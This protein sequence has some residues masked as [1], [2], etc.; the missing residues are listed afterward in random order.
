MRHWQ[1]VSDLI[2]NGAYTAGYSDGRVA[3]VNTYT[4]RRRFFYK[5]FEFILGVGV[6]VLI[7]WIVL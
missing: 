1:F 2:F 6:G 3:G 4:F 7:G 5:T